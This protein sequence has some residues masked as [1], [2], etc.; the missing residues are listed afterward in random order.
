MKCL[1]LTMNAAILLLI[2]SCSSVTNSPS[3][4]SQNLAKSDGADLVLIAPEI[5]FN[6][7]DAFYP[8]RRSKDDPSKIIPTYQWRVC[9]KK[10]I[11]CQKWETKRVEFK[12]LEWFLAN[13]FG[14]S[15]RKRP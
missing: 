2:A 1:S 7:E 15:K 8:L 6:K 9:V 11:W 12:D 10:F 4:S 5:P 3:L 13:G 14:L